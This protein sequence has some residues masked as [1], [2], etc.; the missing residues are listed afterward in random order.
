MQRSR[1]LFWLRALLGTSLSTCR[2]RLLT[3]RGDGTDPREARDFPSEPPILRTPRGRGPWDPGR[4]SG[5]PSPAVDPLRPLL[6]HRATSRSPPV[7][8][9]PPASAHPLWRWLS[10]YLNLLMK[11][12]FTVQSTDGSSSLPKESRLAERES[13]LPPGDGRLGTGRAAE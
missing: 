5:E 2:C 3:R 7:R 8:L 4:G 10:A 11:T 1:L 9:S 6:G 12:C 13:Q